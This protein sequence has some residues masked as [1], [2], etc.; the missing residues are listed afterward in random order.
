MTASHPR[1]LAPRHFVWLLWIALLTPIAQTTA[2]WHALSHARLDA[3][4]A[5]D[6]KQALHETRCDLCFAGAALNGGAI[7]REPPFLPHSTALH[8]APS[9]DSSRFRVALHERLYESRAPPFASH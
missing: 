5:G 7:P 4:H 3:V 8:D 1:P 2:A 9:A 6:G